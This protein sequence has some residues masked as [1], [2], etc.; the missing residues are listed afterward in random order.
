M[1]VTIYPD[2][3][4]GAPPIASGYS[5]KAVIP[6][7][8]SIYRASLSTEFENG[9]EQRRLLWGGERR[10]I[11]LTYPHMSAENATVLRNF[12]V[13]RK[14]SYERFSFFY[15][16]VDSY[17]KELVGVMP[18]PG[19]TV[20]SLPSYGASLLTRILYADDIQLV[21]GVDWTFAAGTSTEDTATFTVAPAPGTI[22]HFTFT[23]RLKINARF[24]QSPLLFSDIKGYW[25][26]LKVK[27]EGLEA[28]VQI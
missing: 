28:Q 18:D 10:N 15:P 16:H 27:L 7:N 20:L 5:I 1:S 2:V 6:F 23:G 9:V 13:D 12:Y 26:T 22:F 8:N 17:V 19:I 11:E 14:G 21:E 4:G 24:S 3:L 25:S